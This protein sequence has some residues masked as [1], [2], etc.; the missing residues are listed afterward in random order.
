MGSRRFL[1]PRGGPFPC[2]LGALRR[3]SS[4]ARSLPSSF[5]FLTK[6]YANCVPRPPGRTHTRRASSLR[7]WRNGFWNQRLAPL[8][9]HWAAL[10]PV[11]GGAQPRGGCHWLTSNVILDA[12]ELKRPKDDFGG[13]GLGRPCTLLASGH[14]RHASDSYIGLGLFCLLNIVPPA[15][16]FFFFYSLRDWL[17]FITARRFAGQ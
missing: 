9:S 13:Q 17:P 2:P 3:P 10:M 14:V 5:P 7:Q 12:R 4:L 8:P 16:S 6:S 11:R 15:N 1:R